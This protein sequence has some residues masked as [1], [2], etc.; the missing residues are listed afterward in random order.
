MA[1]FSWECFWGLGFSGD[2]GGL[3]CE[4]GEAGGEGDYDCCGEEVVEGA[5][6]DVE[7]GD[8]GCCGVCYGSRECDDYVFYYDCEGDEK[9][10]G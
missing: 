1:G 2:G 5:Y 4:V 3:G 6:G 10:D 8:C 7:V 9:D